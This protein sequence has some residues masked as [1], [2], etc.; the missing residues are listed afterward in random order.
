[1]DRIGAVIL[2][3]GAGRRMGGRPKALIDDGGQTW[4]ERAIRLCTD[5]G[6]DG[7]VV[8]VR[9]E[10]VAAAAIARRAGAQVA[11]NPEPELGMF[12]SVL[13]GLGALR[14]A[15]SSGAI[16]HP[17]DHPFV[18]PGTVRALCSALA[19]DRVIAVPC[20]GGRDGHPT[21]LGAAVAAALLDLP[22]TTTFRDALAA[23]GG[24]MVR[25]PVDDPGV[26]DNVN[27][28]L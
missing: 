8:V 10:L 18:E 23:T 24:R 14:D 11:L 22:P 13:A 6:C 26:L 12:S 20:H 27:T 3:A 28:P 1:M 5:G 25:V 15:G 9:P 19:G 2:A 4:L 16:V 21:G 17:V 7:V